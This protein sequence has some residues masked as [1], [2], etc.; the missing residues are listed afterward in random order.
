MARKSLVVK[1]K[2]TAKFSTRK[3]NRCGNCGRSRA[4]MRRFGLCRLC[5]RELALKGEIP[6]ITKASW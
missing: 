1:A 3:Y 5:F 4:Y 2:R 6:G